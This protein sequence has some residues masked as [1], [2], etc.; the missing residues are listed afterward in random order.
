MFVLKEKI[1]IL[2][3]LNLLEVNELLTYIIPFKGLSSGKHNF[4]FHV[5]D[6]F[7]ESMQSNEVYPTHV[8]IN[9]ELD[10]LPGIITLKFSGKGY[11]VVPCDI[12]LEDFKQV[13]EYQRTVVYK[14]GQ[15]ESNDDDVIFIPVSESQIDLS[16]IIYDDILLSLPLQKAHPENKN[17][18]RSCNVEQLKLLD[19]ISV[20]TTAT[21]PRWDALKNLKFED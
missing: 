17:G 18:E 4:S 11:M 9:L 16:Q 3:P 14:I 10:N 12:C 8:D 20:S 13:V 6:K 5:T 19:K 2:Q 7:F 21:D 1:I 15:G